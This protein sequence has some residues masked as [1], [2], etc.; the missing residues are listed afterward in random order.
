MEQSGDF[1]SDK[2]QR[3]QMNSNPDTIYWF[4]G[5]MVVA[6]IG[7]IFSVMVMGSKGVWWMSELSSRVDALR[8]DVER[9]DE[10]VRDLRHAH[11]N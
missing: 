6:N 1:E 7:T 4:V 9:I 2:I 8:E 3:G 10:D 11:N 5:L